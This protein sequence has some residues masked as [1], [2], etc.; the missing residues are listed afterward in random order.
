M[1]INGPNLNMLGVRE[2]EIYGHR[3]YEDICS[4]ISSEAEKLGISVEIVQNNI[5]G[6]IVN[7]IHRAFSESFDG[8]VINPAAYT[9]YSLAIYDALKSVNLPAVEL[10]LSNINSREEYRRISVTAPACKGA[11]CGFGHY[12]YKLA[13]E[14]LSGLIREKNKAV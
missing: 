6:E 1:I 2:K 3:T 4:F 11:I 12:G 7:H 5:E 14:A 10:H 9:H 13:L 8:I